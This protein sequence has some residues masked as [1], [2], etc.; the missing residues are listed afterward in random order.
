MENTQKAFIA[1]GG[2]WSTLENGNEV[3]QLS[4]ETDD[5]EITICGVECVHR[6][7]V[8][9]NDPAWDVTGLVYVAP[10]DQE[11]TEFAAVWLKSRL[12]ALHAELTQALE[13]RQR[14]V[15]V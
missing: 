4:R 6:S 2:Q 10:I 9:I 13:A 5:G 11:A 12:E 14:G 15:S 3:A 1:A 8:A 7:R